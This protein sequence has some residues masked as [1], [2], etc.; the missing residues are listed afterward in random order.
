ME[1]LDCIAL[2]KRHSALIAP[3]IV[4]VSCVRLRYQTNANRATE[5]I[6]RSTVSSQQ[7]CSKSGDKPR[8]GDDHLAN[9][10]S[11][12]VERITCY[13]RHNSRKRRLKH[14]RGPTRSDRFDASGRKTGVCWLS[15]AR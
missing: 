11:I 3:Q 1:A 10:L 15:I 4:V 9:H 14:R 13:K 6:L 12:N 2:I 5:F 8:T 7:Q